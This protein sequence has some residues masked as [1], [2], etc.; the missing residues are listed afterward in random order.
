MMSLDDIDNENGTYYIVYSQNLLFNLLG[1]AIGDDTQHV[2]R[3]FDPQKSF[4][5]SLA[6]G[7]EE[8]YNY[9]KIN[10][11]AG[12]LSQ[13]VPDY[14]NINGGYGVFSS[15]LNIEKHVRLS[16][17]TQSDLIGVSDWNFS[18]GDF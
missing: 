18:Q 7:G 13:S 5:I 3:V 12:G 10:Q 11:G 6:A 1:S 9:I 2:S 15:R 17:R 14:T 16:A 8:L 4:V